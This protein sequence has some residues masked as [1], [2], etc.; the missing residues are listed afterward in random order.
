MKN[1]TKKTVFV[2]F[3]MFTTALFSQENTKEILPCPLLEDRVKY[4]N[5]INQEDL[6]KRLI[7]LA[8]DSLE[9]REKGKRG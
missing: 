5:T 6:K 1:N 3:F 7:F 9:G 2:L 8:S 4:A